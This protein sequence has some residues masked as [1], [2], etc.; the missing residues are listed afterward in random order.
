MKPGVAHGAHPCLRPPLGATA[1]A[2]GRLIKGGPALARGKGQYWTD[3]L[4][5]VQL[6][7]VGVVAI[8]QQCRATLIAADHALSGL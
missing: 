3:V 1:S 2:Q 4:D 7:Y 5:L 8:I 6:C